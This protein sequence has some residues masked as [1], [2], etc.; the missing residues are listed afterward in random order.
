MNKLS[1][2][3]L[4]GFGAA[5]AAAISYDASILTTSLGLSL[6]GGEGVIALTSLTLSITL[7]ALGARG[8]LVQ[9]TRKPSHAAN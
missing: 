4:I 7:I 9:R 6:Y 2:A 8:L 5:L 1:S 3:L